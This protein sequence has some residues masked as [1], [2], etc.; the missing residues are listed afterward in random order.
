M[1]QLD[2]LTVIGK[3]FLL[4]AAIAV[5][6]KSLGPRLAIPETSSV[7]LLFVLLPPVLVGLALALQQLGQRG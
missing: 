7:A 4:S 5:G 2:S 3:V 6:I 1:M